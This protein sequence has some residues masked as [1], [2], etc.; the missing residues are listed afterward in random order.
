MHRPPHPQRSR[1]LLMLLLANLFWGLSFPLIKGIAGV[2]ERLLPG[3]S[4]WFI[5]GS[6]LVPRFFLGALILSAFCWRGLRT[7]TRLELKQ[8][9]ALA[10]F[11]VVGMIFQN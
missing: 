7:L 5:A 6:A 10:S 8:G 9:L 3:S 4:S 11:S 2:H 1:A